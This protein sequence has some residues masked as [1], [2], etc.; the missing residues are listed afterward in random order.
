MHLEQGKPFPRLGGTTSKGKTLNMPDDL[1]G[2][3]AVL[4]FYR[5]HW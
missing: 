2:K 4:L 1:R 3:W 5:G